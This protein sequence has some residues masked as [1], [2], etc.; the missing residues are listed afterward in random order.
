MFIYKQ[1]EHYKG[2]FFVSENK[3]LGILFV[4]KKGAVRWVRKE[5]CNEELNKFYVSSDALLL[6]SLS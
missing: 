3:M 5:L 6:M 2:I 4:R 1:Y